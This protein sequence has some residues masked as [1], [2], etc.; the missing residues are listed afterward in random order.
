[1]AANERS[2]IPRVPDS[3][4][5]AA[6]GA[7]PRGGFRPGY[8]V[9]V[10]L[11]V[12]VIGLL[13]VMIAAEAAGL[14]AVPKETGTVVVLAI[15]AVALMVMIGL[16][17]AAALGSAAEGRQRKALERLLASRRQTLGPDHPETLAV[18]AGL[19]TLLGRRGGLLWLAAD[20][21][22]ELLERQ[23]RVL[24]DDH[25]DVLTTRAAI[26][27]WRSKS[28]H[29]D[30]GLAAAAYHDL[31]VASERALGHADPRTAAARANAAF[32]AERASCQPQR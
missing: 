12:A 18:Q 21:S 23:R 6:P 29:S 25:P 13:L 8:A 22:A 19:I 1:M 24:G 17:L 2:E 9:V 15:M 32:W 3:E 31:M 10:T 4:L 20:E 16:P 5:W 7:S 11:V 14:D 26:A 30:P 28:Q 27:Y